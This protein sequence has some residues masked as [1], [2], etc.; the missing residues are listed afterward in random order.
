MNQILTK[1]TKNSKKYWVHVQEYSWM[2]KRRQRCRKICSSL[3]AKF[4]H[5]DVMLQ[6]SGFETIWNAAFKQWVGF[7]DTWRIVGIGTDVCERGNRKCTEKEASVCW[8]FWTIVNKNVLSNVMHYFAS[9]FP[10]CQVVPD[11]WVRDVM[12]V[13]EGHFL[14]MT[15]ARCIL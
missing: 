11:G 15:V 12:N 14:F 7:G 5:C 9:K 2:K 10:R 4:M 13:V 6:F 1:I 3:D 8:P